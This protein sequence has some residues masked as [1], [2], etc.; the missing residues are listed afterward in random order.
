MGQGLE[1]MQTFSV[2]ATSSGKKVKISPIILPKISNLP[3]RIPERTRGRRNRSLIVA[4]KLIYINKKD[5]P[6]K[7][8]L[9]I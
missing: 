5:Q 2:I 9:V 3:N 4:T 1:V 7:I 6:I 8:G